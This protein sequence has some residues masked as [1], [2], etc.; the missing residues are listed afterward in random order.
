MKR[1]YLI[2]L[3]AALLAAPMLRAQSYAGLPLTYEKVDV[4]KLT[5][6]VEKSNAEIADPKKSTK[7]AT[8]IKRGETLLT[9]EE[10]PINGLFTGLDETT[11]KL[12]FG[13]APKES[14]TLGE[15]K[16]MLYTY[17]HFKAYLKDGKLEFYVPTT[18]IV[19]GAIP[20]AYDAFAKAYDLDA[21]SVKKVSVGMQ[22]IHTR[23]FENGAT[24][25]N[26]KDFKT[27]ADNFRLAYKASVHPAM[28]HPDTVS[29]YN[30]GFLGTLAGDYANAIKDLDASIALGYEG[31]GEAYFYKFFCLY[32]LGQ[33]DEATKVLEEGLA[34]YPNNDSIISALLDI[35]SSEPDKDP[36]NLIPLVLNVI[37]QN[38]TNAD[39]YVGL[40]RVYDKLGQSEN[41]IDA[42][43]NAIAVNPENFLANYYLGFYLAKKGDAAD[44]ELRKMTITSRAQYQAA[45]ADVNKI[46]SDA[47]PPLEK[48]YEINP[49]E[50]ATIEL[51]KN[52][53][54][55]L[56]ETE[57]MEA[58]YEKYDAL[59]KALPS[60]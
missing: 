26:L 53:T 58:K 38:P 55:R 12:T 46:Y 15:A 13:N 42:A 29:L 34:K 47:V 14:V 31:D 10:K 16:Y 8:W 44:G 6:E 57:G 49:E 39:L 59:Y 3:G 40:A 20:L 9:V 50:P 43:R 41:A 5:K 36:T 48:A 18:I 60:K 7:A 54:F 35:Y 25:F 4:A 2:V 28:A 21:K 52:L 51:L 22:K 24:Y 37:A 30:A 23:S 56:R 19:E 11:F 33:K 32:Q 45:L 1:L 17:E 27:A